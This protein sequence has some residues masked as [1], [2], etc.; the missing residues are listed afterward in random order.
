MRPLLAFFIAVLVTS[1]NAAPPNVVLIMTDDQGFGDFGATGNPII[2][3]P[4]LDGMSRQSAGLT[5]FYV[6]P[7]CSPTR[8]S[9]LT[10]RY[11]FRT[12]CI[13]TWL[14]RSM[15]EPDEVT[16]AEILSKAGYATGIFGKWHLGSCYPMRPMDQGFGESLVH[17]GGGLAQPSEPRENNRRYTDPI[18]FHN[19]VKVKTSGYCTDVYFDAA[20]KFIRASQS[21]NQP[22]FAYIATNAPHGPLHDVPEDLRLD[23]MTKGEE[24]LELLPTAPGDPA[25]AIDRL[26]RI[27]S[28]ITNIDQNVGRLFE[29]L[30]ELGITKETLVI[31]LTDN[32]PAGKR[33]VGPF[34]GAKTQVLEGGIRT[35][36]WFHWPGTL[37][38]S[39]RRD[40]LAA[41]IDIL[42]TIL[43][44]CEVA[45]PNDTK[46]DGRSLLEVLRDGQVDWSNRTVAIQSH[47]GD[48]PTRYH[49][50]MVRDE[51]WKLL[52]PSGFQT[53]KFQGSPEFELYDL[54]AD[55]GETRN[56]A[57]EEPE[58]VAR[59]KRRYDEW[60]D[61][62]SSTRPN[63]YAPPR[64]RI[65]S[66][67]ERTTVLTRQTWRA[68][69]WSGKSV[70]KWLVHV[71]KTGPYDVEVM[72]DADVKV[73][74][75]TFTDGVATHSLVGNLD[76]DKTVFSGL[77]L[78][79]GDCDL[80]AQIKASDG[81]TYG[82]Y[83]V[84]ISQ[85]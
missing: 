39:L 43:D 55:P 5:N 73:T 27:F 6:N 21:S 71:E 41:H 24:L 61:D 66:D 84:H 12:R 38:A 34:R 19:G 54:T 18:L 36:I 13:D 22:F 14:G 49:N 67:M 20:A 48:T 60:F 10:G 69:D 50:F 76:G 9:L 59:L 29:Q 31:F 16:I 63:N 80:V 53:Q 15:M 82:A 62:V 64:I 65:G 30:A 57:T 37:Q 11:N 40:E 35:P 75:V 47:R 77:S 51:K 4:N 44:A 68:A 8:A 28:M 25:Q 79:T 2:Q 42:P 56:L 3:T 32:G 17:R 7:V 46:I 26:S 52:H 45:L 70:G 85:Q 81:A 78:P 74:E 33:F 58:I 83:Q 72:F 1:L 23:Y